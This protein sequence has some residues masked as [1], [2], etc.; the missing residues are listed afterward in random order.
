MLRY[1]HSRFFTSPARSVLVTGA[2]IQVINTS[3]GDILCSTASFDA[4]VKDAVV[5]SGPIR[6]AAISRSGN[7]IATAAD[8]KQL[9][10]WELASLALMS[11]RELPKKP[12][13]ID[14]TRNDDILVADKFGDVFRYPLHPDPKAKHKQDNNDALVSHENPSGGHLVL[15]HVSVLTGCLLT[16]NEDFVITS[17]RDEHIRVSWYPQGYV[18]ET[19]CLGHE[20]YVSAIHIPSFAQTSLVSGGGDPDLKVWDWMTGRLQRS[21]GVFA[22][23]EPFIAVRAPKRGRKLRED[24]DADAENSKGKGGRRKKGK[25]NR[26]ATRDDTE[27]PPGTPSVGA[28]NNQDVGGTDFVF[29]VHKI[30]SFVSNSSNYIVF[31]VVGATALF[32]FTLADNVEQPPICHFDFG[33]PVIDFTVADDL[34]WVLLDPEYQGNASTESRGNLV[35]VVTWQSDQFVEAGSSSLLESLNLACVIP[36][37]ATDLKTLDPYSDLVSLPK[38]VGGELGEQERDQSEHPEGLDTVAVEG[39]SAIGSDKPLPKRT[40]GR[41]KHKL[42]LQRL[43]E[44]KGD[45]AGS[46]VPSSK[47]QRAE[48]G[49]DDIQEDVDMES[50]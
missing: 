19:Y 14:F 16:P 40:L 31:S 21:I 48:A 1:P 15:G 3:S 20:K 38:H 13:A 32:A 9:K 30:D 47:R 49:E 24:D 42:A 18:I 50:T 4:E 2:H 17:D 22:A 12:T 35:R 36:A 7:H 25:V 29:V 34:I 46:E 39:T 27:E 26:N 11:S 6:C 23:V 28:A 8:D 45:R 43:Q 37:T 33:C 41:L 5:K 44:E 10:V